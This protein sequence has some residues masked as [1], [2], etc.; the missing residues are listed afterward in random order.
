MPVP[1]Y[2]PLSGHF[3][4][5]P[6]AHREA[7]LQGDAWMATTNAVIDAAGYEADPARRETLWA[8]LTA[9]VRANGA[10]DY[11]PSAQ[12]AARRRAYAGPASAAAVAPGEGLRPD[13]M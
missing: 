11:G 6:E 9:L 10:D 3:D 13:T 5:P 8:L 1:S 4:W 2:R 7:R 12:P